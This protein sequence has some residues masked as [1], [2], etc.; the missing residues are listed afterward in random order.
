MRCDC[1]K[2]AR[3]LVCNKHLNA[4]RDALLHFDYAEIAL[5]SEWH[6]AAK[7]ALD[8]AGRFH[9]RRIADDSR[10]L[11][12]RSKKLKYPARHLD[13]GVPP[14]LQIPHPCPN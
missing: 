2:I 9:E 6:I 13:C 1:A 14:R 12:Q 10:G 4:Y 7:G 11:N 3:R 5:F 8:D